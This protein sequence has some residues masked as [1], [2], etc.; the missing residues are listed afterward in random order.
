M[1]CSAPCQNIGGCLEGVG[2]GRCPKASGS[3]WLNAIRQLSELVGR[4]RS[5]S[6]R[7]VPLQLG[8]LRW[9]APAGSAPCHLCRQQATNNRCGEASPKA[10]THVKHLCAPPQAAPLTRLC[11]TGAPAACSQAAPCTSCYLRGSALC[12]QRMH[13]PRQAGGRVPD[14]CAGAVDTTSAN[15]RHRSHPMPCAPLQHQLG[16]LKPGGRPVARSTYPGAVRG[17]ASVA[18]LRLQRRQSRMRPAGAHQGCGCL[19]HRLRG[20]SVRIWDHRG[21]ESVTGS[22]DRSG[23]TELPEHC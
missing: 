3:C 2:L 16:A 18:A 14:A 17:I 11:A 12:W 19:T 15:Q 5:A 9:Q 6:R 8:R 20:C 7:R 23:L 21:A 1:P 4:C 13:T 22:R 10:L